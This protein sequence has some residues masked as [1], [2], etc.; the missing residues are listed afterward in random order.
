MLIVICIVVAVVVAMVIFPTPTTPEPPT[1]AEAS[2][3]NKACKAD[4]CPTLRIHPGFL[5][6]PVSVICFNGFVFES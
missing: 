5:S 1:L 6:C 2:T 3:V 4:T